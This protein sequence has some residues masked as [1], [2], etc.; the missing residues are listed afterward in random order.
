MEINIRQ[1]PY[2][3]FF[4]NHK[5][6]LLISKLKEKKNVIFLN[7]KKYVYTIFFIFEIYYDQNQVVN[8]FLAKGSFFLRKSSQAMT[9]II[10]DEDD[11]HR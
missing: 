7:Y 6:F 10:K 8:W 11:D 5:I 1:Q 9:I 3:F 2:E 4:L